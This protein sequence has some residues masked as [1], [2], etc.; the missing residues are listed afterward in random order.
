MALQVRVRMLLSFIAHVD[1]YKIMVGVYNT[2][3]VYC[4]MLDACG[5]LCL[6]FS[7]MV[8]VGTYRYYLMP[9]GM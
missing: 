9:R 4:R 1:G 8:D 7:E 3:V 2:I 5:R 6:P